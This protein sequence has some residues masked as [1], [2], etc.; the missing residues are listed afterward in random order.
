MYENNGTEYFKSEMS[1]NN[2]MIMMFIFPGVIFSH[3]SQNTADAHSGLLEDAKHLK[4]KS[5]REFLVSN[6]TCKNLEVTAPS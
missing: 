5:S 3:W 2:H 1:L 6:S 4:K